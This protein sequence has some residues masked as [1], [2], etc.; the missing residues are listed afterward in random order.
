MHF[1]LLNIMLLV[2]KNYGRQLQHI[3]A[4]LYAFLLKI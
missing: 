2:F 1:S 3:K 4:D